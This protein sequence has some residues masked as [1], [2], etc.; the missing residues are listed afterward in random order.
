MLDI[1]TEPTRD[2]LSDHTQPGLPRLVC[3]THARLG[4]QATPQQVADELRRQGVETT[5]EDVKA[6]WPEGGKLSG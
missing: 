2:E 4:P 6:C 3:E 1:T 5:V